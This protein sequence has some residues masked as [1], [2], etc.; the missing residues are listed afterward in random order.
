MGKKTLSVKS[1]LT[2][3]LGIFGLQLFIGYINTYQS[4]FY[5]SMFGADLM[6]VAVIILVAKIV[7]SLADP[8]IGNLIDRSNFKMGKM[9][10]FILMSAFPIAFLTTLMFIVIDFKTDIGMYIY[11]VITTLLWNI[12][13]SFA[14][15][16]SQGMLA[17]LSPNAEERNSAAGI[18]NILKSIGLTVPS[19]AI[20]VICILTKSE[21]G[22]IT[23]K[24]Y[25]I[26]AIAFGI[27]GLALY[28]LIPFFTKETV[29]ITNNRMSLK[30]MVKE[31]KANRMLLIVFLTFILG[32]GRNMAMGIGVQAG[33]VLLKDGVN[34][35]L[36]GFM[37]GENLAWLIGLTSGV[38]SMASIVLAPAINKKWG[39][40]KTFIVFATYAGIVCI[41]ACALYVS[42]IMAFRSLWAILC[43]QLFVGVGFGPNGYLPM[44]MVSDIVDYREWQTGKRTEGTQFAVLSLSNKISNA[45]SVA[46]GIF[47]V[48]AA[49]YN[50][51]KIAKGLIT[52]TPT[53]QNW[54]F[55]AYIG[56]PGICMLLSMVPVFYYKIT[57]K[58][59]EEMYADLT[60]RR[61]NA[62]Q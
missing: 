54:V 33:A 44:V 56:I 14:D 39:E 42:G 58:V 12:A 8:F 46:V 25:L 18:T 9:R 17:V 2:Y 4:Q 59:K 13:M 7:S 60:I 49:G 51:E 26:A 61:K 3:A 11:I 6:V 20:P 41:L 29:P 45:L 62:S 28:L 22:A 30:D 5:T 31:L 48:G 55:F 19:L 27:I 57:Q 37:A 50:A 10:P 38:S 21:N 24:E 52:I 16:P 34:L 40:K 32:F 1:A 15:I 23:S 36:I 53:M 47:I 35:P 43:Y